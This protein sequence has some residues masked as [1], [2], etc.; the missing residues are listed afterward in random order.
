MTI[1]ATLL[2]LLFWLLLFPPAGMSRAMTE[3]KYYAR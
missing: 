3:R 1:E 2:G